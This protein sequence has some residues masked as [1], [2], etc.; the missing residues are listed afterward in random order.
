MG[1]KE[2][3]KV[4]GKALTIISAVLW[5]WGLYMAFTTI[6]IISVLEELPRTVFIFI[7]FYIPLFYFSWGK[8]GKSKAFRIWGKIVSILMA[9][10]LVLSILAGIIYG[11]ISDIISPASL[12]YFILN[13]LLAI[14]LGYFSW[15]D[16]SK[17]KPKRKKKS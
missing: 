11:F 15:F 7:A 3:M 1:T 4:I 12:P 2:V 5:I 9:L 13:I 17:T 16:K 10:Y 8:K 6:P 14:T